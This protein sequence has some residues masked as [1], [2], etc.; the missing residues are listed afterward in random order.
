MQIVTSSSLLLLSITFGIVYKGAFL[1][2]NLYEENHTLWLILLY[3][4]YAAGGILTAGAIALLVL[5]ILKAVK[6][7][8][9][10]IKCAMLWLPAAVCCGAILL[11]SV[12]EAVYLYMLYE[13]ICAYTLAITVGN[14]FSFKKKSKS[15]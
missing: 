3:I 6:G 9:L 15:Q 12:F 1:D 10:P 2:F 7:D 5:S 13:S 8:L 4:E 14:S 11:L